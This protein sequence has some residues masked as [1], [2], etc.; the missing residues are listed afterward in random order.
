MLMNCEVLINF[1]AKVQEDSDIRHLMVFTFLEELLEAL[2]KSK[3]SEKATKFEKIGHNNL[4][5]TQSICTQYYCFEN[6]GR[7]VTL[8]K[9]RSKIWI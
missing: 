6:M 1:G 4:L 7:F 8:K 3:F 5:V 9:I 2:L